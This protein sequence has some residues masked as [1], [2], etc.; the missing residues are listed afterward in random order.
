LELSLDDPLANV[1]N[2]VAFEQEMVVG[3]VDRAVA[4]VIELRGM[5]PEIEEFLWAKSDHRIYPKAFG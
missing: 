3:E 2:P 5:Q 1:V 4:H